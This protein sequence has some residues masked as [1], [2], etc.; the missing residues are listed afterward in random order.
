MKKNFF[1]KSISKILILVFVFFINQPFILAYN[2]KANDS[3]NIE[4]HLL[5]IVN[6]SN[7]YVSKKISKD[8]CLDKMIKEHLILEKEL[9][10]FLEKCDSQELNKLLEFL[11]KNSETTRH[12]LT[13]SNQEILNEFSNNLIKSNLD[14]SLRIKK[15]LKS[16][17][18]SS[19]VR[20]CPG[21]CLIVGFYV[22]SSLVIG[23]YLFT[24]VY[25]DHGDHSV[26]YEQ[27]TPLNECNACMTVGT[28]VCP[29]CDGYGCSSCHNDGRI[30][31]PSC[32]GS[33]FEGI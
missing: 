24:T 18:F 3:K 20:I 4:S 8:E 30:T 27:Q 10:F 7:S 14:T 1:T 16:Y 15:I 31:C 26:T 32:K 28:I 6:L 23:S 5:Q 11:E 2:E 17:L 21:G 29:N 9:L 33:G 13:I 19:D 22:I 12:L 25:E